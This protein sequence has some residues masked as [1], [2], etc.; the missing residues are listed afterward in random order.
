MDK[1]PSFQQ[2]NQLCHFEKSYPGNHRISINKNENDDGGA[3]SL[4]SLDFPPSS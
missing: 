1:E 2:N 3:A 4:I